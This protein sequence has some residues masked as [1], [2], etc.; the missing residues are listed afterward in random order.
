MNHHP[1]SHWG[2][3]REGIE[4]DTDGVLPAQATR[5]N[6]GNLT[7]TLVLAE[8]CGICNALRIQ[9]QD[10]AL[11]EWRGVKYIDA[12]CKGDATRQ[13]YPELILSSHATTGTGGNDNGGRCL[14][15]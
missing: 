7:P 14:L 13:W 3:I 2:D 10:N 1:M 11:Y 15:H 8:R 12:A 6:R 9:H 4:T 5:N